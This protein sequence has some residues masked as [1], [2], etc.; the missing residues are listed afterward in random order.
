M[1]EV[2]LGGTAPAPLA[3]YLKALAVLRLVAEQADPN[4]R[5]FWRG[6]TFVLR[7]SLDEAGL[8]DFFLHRY[9]PTPVVGPWNGGSG[10][11]PKDNKGGIQPLGESE[12]PRFADYGAAI[13]I[14]RGILERLGITEKATDVAKLRLQQQCRA[15]LPDRAL[16]WFDAAL[17]LMSD[18]PAYPALLGTGGND[19][20]LDFSNNFMQRFAELFDCAA[21]Q[22]NA[23]AEQYLRGS[24]L[25]TAMRGLRSDVPVGQFNPGGAGGANGTSGYD[26]GSLVNPWDFV[27]MIEGALLFAASNARRLG[28]STSSVLAC[29]F[30]VHPVGVG[31][32][33]AAQIDEK[34]TRSELWVPLWN[35]PVGL[36]ELRVLMAEGRAQVGG[37]RAANGVDFA[38][39]VAS[40][41]VDRGISS[42][43]RYAFQERNGQAKLALPLDRY[44]V[45][46]QPQ[47]ELLS[48]L[49]EGAWLDRFRSRAA[50]DKTPSSVR[51]ALRCFDE[52]VM[53]LCGRPPSPALLQDLLVTLG[54]LERSL[55]RSLTWT[56]PSAKDKPRTPPCPPLRPE[57]IS[58]A[59]DGSPEFR[60]AVTL[61]GLHGEPSLRAHLE[62]A[63]YKGSRAQW[64]DNPS[65]DVVWHEGDPI[66]VMNAI[67]ARRLVLAAGEGKKGGIGYARVPAR[68]GDVVDLIEGRVDPDRVL[69]LV[70]GLMLVDPRDDWPKPQGHDARPS[71]TPALYALVKLCLAG[72][73]V[74]DVEIPLVPEIHRRL[75]GGDVDQAARLS[76][77]RLRASGLPTII[78]DLHHADGAMA[79]RIGAA[80]MFPLD[81]RGLERLASTVH[82][83]VVDDAEL[84]SQ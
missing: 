62:P 67:L 76:S 14:A 57:W 71:F 17:V 56:N 30:S 81:A 83:R 65:R 38:R 4:A 32:G 53:A 68:L 20:R 69:D 46:R 50:D 41:G 40:L 44:R 37:R 6:E 43:Q 10:F 24:L 31:Y 33:S 47:A 70:W 59:D 74:Y 8:V 84:V 23:G 28:A 27:F 21:G 7:S 82:A 80:L 51:R 48:D 66:G 35:A 58:Q 5:G 77:R 9:S 52:S 42:F 25:G 15:A 60:L 19:G 16:E 49:D 54:G 73:P 61:A 11:Y 1:H 22:P 64:E 12:A 2:A 75:V 78:G 72:R 18:G 63:V 26:A 79:A 13:R 55:A 29:P 34:S 39:A 45:T 36:A 3:H